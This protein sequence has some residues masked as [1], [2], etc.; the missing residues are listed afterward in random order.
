MSQHNSQ[1]DAVVTVFA[2]PASECAGTNTW[3]NAVLAFEHR[4]AKRYGNRV[5]FKAAPLFSPEFF[6]NP[7]VTEAVQQGAE[8]PI[9]TLNGRVIQRGGKLSERIIRE[10]LEKLGILPNA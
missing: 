5:R 2:P 8:A 4:F 3:E 1:S 7:A 6:Q 9:I 10:E